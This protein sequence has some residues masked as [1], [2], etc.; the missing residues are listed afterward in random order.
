MTTPADHFGH[1]RA[2]MKTCRKTKSM[3]GCAPRA[4][5]KVGVVLC[6]RHN[7]MDVDLKLASHVRAASA[8][9][10]WPLATHDG[11]PGARFR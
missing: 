4:H 10:R 11:V 9:L 1:Q 7:G 6:S 5:T 3:R 2:R 8:L